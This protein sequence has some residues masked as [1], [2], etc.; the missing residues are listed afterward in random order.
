GGGTLAA[1]DTRNW[2]AANPA[3]TFVAQGGSNSNCGIPIKPT[4][5]LVNI[6]VAN[7]GAGPAFLV[8]WPYNQVRPN[9]A[10]LNWTAA[11]TQVANAV[12]V[13]LCT[14][15]CADDFSFY[16]SSGTDVI[17]DVAGYFARPKHY[18][19]THVITGLAAIDS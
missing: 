17:A 5:V 10:T 8:A 4:A 11:N 19:G 14:G 3:G 18:G 2:L 16:V 12:I 6:T 9:A 7:T 1:G 13:P 15:T